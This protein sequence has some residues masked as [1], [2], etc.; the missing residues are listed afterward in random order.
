LLAILSRS[1]KLWA[2]GTLVLWAAVTCFAAQRSFPR[3]VRIGNLSAVTW[4]A[5]VTID[6]KALPIS[7]G[8]RIFDQ[9]NAALLPSQLIGLGK[10]AYKLDISGFVHTI[11]L[12]TPEEAALLSQPPPQ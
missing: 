8:F 3:E 7:P 2:L 10:A 4:P 5:S 12:L 9:R 11:W 6:G 1:F